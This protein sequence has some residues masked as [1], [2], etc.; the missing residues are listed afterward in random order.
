MTTRAVPGQDLIAS[1][2]EAGITCIRGNTLLGLTRIDFMQRGP[3]TTQEECD[4]P[5]EV[6]NW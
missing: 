5:S 1:V 3:G 2:E 6:E 4:G